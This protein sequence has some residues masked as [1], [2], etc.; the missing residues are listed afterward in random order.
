MWI[1]IALVSGLASLAGY[2]LFQD[3]SP[4]VVAFVLTFA[5]GAILTMLAS[6]MM[7]EAYEHGGKL[8]GVF[9]TIG[10]AIRAHNPPARLTRAWNPRRSPRGT[11]HDNIPAQRPG[12]SDSHSSCRGRCRIGLLGL[13]RDLGDPRP[14]CGPVRIG[15]CRRRGSPTT[16]SEGRL[17]S[18]CNCCRLPASPSCGS[19]VCSATASVRARTASSPRSSS[20]VACSS[21][22]CSSHPARL[23]AVCFPRRPMR[24]QEVPWR[25]CGPSGGDPSPT[26]PASTDCGWPPCSRSRPPQSPHGWGWSRVGSRSLGTSRPWCS[27]LVSA[28][29]PGS[30]WCSRGWVFILSAYILIAAFRHQGGRDRQR[31]TVRVQRASAGVATDFMH[32]G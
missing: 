7:P 10:F 23:Q 5:A 15:G 22:P 19:S 8:A 27:C 21:S 12:R 4:G 25:T 14:L 9:T 6:T 18:A 16:A 29:C 20:A 1:S 28:S 17:R 30:S 13:V 26:T 32:F 2:A 3:A 31:H 11:T 24:S